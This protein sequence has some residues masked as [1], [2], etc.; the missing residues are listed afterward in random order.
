MKILQG[1]LSYFVII[2]MIL[3][4]LKNIKLPMWCFVGLGSAL[5]GFILLIA[6]PGNYIRL[7]YVVSDIEFLKK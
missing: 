1:R 5:L 3:C 2:F 4:K 7:D 6:A